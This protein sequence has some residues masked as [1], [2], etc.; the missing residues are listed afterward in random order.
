M[1]TKKGNVILIPCPIS[2]GMTETIP[3]AT[4][5]AIYSTKYFAVEKAKTA[6]HFLK[7]IGHPDPITSLFIHE[8]VT[9]KLENEAFFKHLFDGND[10][11]VLSEAGNPC[12]ADPGHSIVTFAHRHD[13]KVIPL[14]GPSSILLALI[15]SGFNGQNF[16]FHGYL[17]AKKPELKNQLKALESQVQKSSQTQIFMETPYRVSFMM[18]T[19]LQTLK[20]ESLLCVAADLTG[21]KEFICQKSIKR[22]IT[23]GFDDFIKKPS[24]FLIGKTTFLWFLGFIS[25]NNF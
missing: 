25:L 10:I 18:E 21:E 14:V 12:I 23:D 5:N 16:T 7:D 11:G 8:F 3:Q 17:S 15:S 1:S 2:D 19:L 4:V 24:I 6:R 13:I 22:W 9:S 20:P